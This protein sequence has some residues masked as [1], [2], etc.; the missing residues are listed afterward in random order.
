MTDQVAYDAAIENLLQLLGQ[1]RR[2]VA[3]LQD[4]LA[5]KQEAERA[6]A[7][8]LMRLQGWVREVVDAH[9]Q[10]DLPRFAEA[11]VFAGTLADDDP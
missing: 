1:E 3:D 7:I 11:L 10:G 4:T 9:L 6:L 5:L 2:H 8:R